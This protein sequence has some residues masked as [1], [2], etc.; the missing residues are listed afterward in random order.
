MP[1][2]FKPVKEK[3]EFVPDICVYTDGACSNNGRENAIAGIGVF[4]GKDD[5]RNVSRRISGRQTNNTAELSAII[6]VYRIL[7]REIHAGYNIV[8][9]SDSQVAIGWCTTT[10]A[11]YSKNN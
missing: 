8:I 4:F 5:E 6:E 1:C 2:F 10:G 11:K 3:T 7:E 9:C